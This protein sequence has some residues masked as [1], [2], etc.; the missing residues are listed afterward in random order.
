[1][2]KIWGNGPLGPLATSVS[3]NSHNQFNLHSALC[4]SFPHN[5]QL[6]IFIKQTKLNHV[7]CSYLGTMYFKP[8]PEHFFD[9]KTFLKGL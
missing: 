3:L 8:L 2:L 6:S 4:V 1:M 5:Q 9:F 7:I